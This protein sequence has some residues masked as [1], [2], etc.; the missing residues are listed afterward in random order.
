MKL[1]QFDPKIISITQ[2][3]RDMDALEKVLALESEA[4]VMRN[5]SLLFVAIAPDKYKEVMATRKG[6]SFDQA[7]GAAAELRAKYKHKKGSPAS[8]YVSRMRDERIK[9][10]KKV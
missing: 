7:A 5:Q 9:R 4:W 10:W 6:L 8:D 2:L 3:R 1:A